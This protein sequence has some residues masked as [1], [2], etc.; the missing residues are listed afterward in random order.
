MQPREPLT[1][2]LSPPAGRGRA[3]V[4][5]SI[6]VGRLR[7]RLKLG[8]LSPSNGERDRVR[9]HGRLTFG[10]F[11]FASPAKAGVHLSAAGA[12]EG[13]VPAFAGTPILGAIAIAA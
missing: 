5:F 3:G 10:R 9:G 6:R 11:H 12:V 13:W 4:G 8:S 7:V 1:P 2:A